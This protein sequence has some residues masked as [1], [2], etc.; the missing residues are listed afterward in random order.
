MMFNEAILSFGDKMLHV[1]VCDTEMKRS[2]GLM[3]VTDMPFDCGMLF[4]MDSPAP[5]NF[6]MKNTLIPLDIAFVDESMRILKIG[7]MKPGVGQC[8]CN[9]PVSYAVEANAGWFS[10]N[11][12]MEGDTMA[13]DDGKVQIGSVVDE[14][15]RELWERPTCFSDIVYRP[16]SEMFFKTLRE[17][18]TRVGSLNEGIVPFDWFTKEALSTDIGEFGIYEGVTV[19]LD[20]PIPEEFHQELY[21]GKKLPKGAR[22]NQPKRG[23]TGKFH[24]YVRDPSTKNIKKV[25]FGAKGMSVGIHNPKR[26]KSFVS[27]HNCHKA[28]DKTSASYWSCRLP[29]YWKQLGLKKT[30]HKFW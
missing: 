19:P 24:V 25:S 1:G 27:R 23:G 6:W 22:L 26:I 28:N 30:S 17:M 16:F 18:K 29:R 7:N 3:H 13:I 9:S 12:I 2:A 10:K 21:E 5:A 11:G 4:V 20:I 15:M 8:G 14:I